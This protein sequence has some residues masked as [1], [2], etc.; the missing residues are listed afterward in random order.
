MPSLDKIAPVTA[1][2]SLS[3]S[4][5]VPKGHKLYHP[6]NFISENYGNPESILKAFGSILDLDKGI[7][8]LF[9]SKKKLSFE[10]TVNLLRYTL[11]A[12]FYGL[13][14]GIKVKKYIKQIYKGELSEY[15]KR[16]ILV[17]KLLE[18]KSDSYKE[19]WHA[20]YLNEDILEWVLK[21]PDTEG[22]KILGY[23]NMSLEKIE[24]MPEDLESMY[25][26]FEFQEKK[27]L[28]HIV[29]RTFGQISFLES[30]L[31]IGQCPPITLDIVKELEMLIL[32]NFILTFNIKE[33]VLEFKGSIVTKRRAVV[34]EIINQFDV[35][36]L[37]AEI[38]KILKHGRKRGYGF[39]GIQGTGKT[40]ILKKIEEILVNLIIIKISPDEFSTSA[41]IKRCFN[42]IHTIQPALVVIED[43][44]AFR[45]QEKNERVGTFINEMDDPDLNAV[46]L[47]SINDPEMIHRTI[48]DRPGRFDEIFEIKP[49]QSE[50]EAYD[51]MASKYHKLLSSYTD[52]KEIPFP[53][54]EKFNHGILQ[55]C[56]TNRFTQAELTS[57]IIE[58]VF[59]NTDN[60]EKLNFN[61]AI[62]KAINSF[63]T[64]KRSLKTYKFYEKE[65]ISEVYD[66]DEECT[67]KED[68]GLIKAVKPA[69]R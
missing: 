20:T 26:L 17:S 66:D 7:R 22:F 65:S 31:F 38:I 36:P 51:V 68:P 39:I 44:D 18:I 42:L 28:L 52:F 49:P 33:N 13:E 16:D 46:F 30:I 29:T 50:Q 40:I 47:V 61:D 5:L 53:E 34:D 56:V 12:S 43:L 10:N 19:R 27:L 2:D 3:L 21:S 41:G 45:F 9:T 32:K 69:L 11:P 57:G 54:F 1:G 6:F 55:R 24:K 60:P 37:V 67:K 4:S 15:E 23:Y 62:K 48:I 63:E 59:L 35:E 8:T 25:I 58:K 14:M 64:S